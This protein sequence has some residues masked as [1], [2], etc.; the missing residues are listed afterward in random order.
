MLI[1]QQAMRRLVLLHLRELQSKTDGKLDDVHAKHDQYFA[2][3]VVLI[4]DDSQF[5]GLAYLGP[6]ESRMFSVTSWNYAT[7]YYSFGHEIAH[8]LGC[9][10]DRGTSSAYN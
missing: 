8:N 9:Q 7:G 3:V 2:D 10:H 5:C 4:I 6:S 1:A